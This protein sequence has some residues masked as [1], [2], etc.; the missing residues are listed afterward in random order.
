LLDAVFSEAGFTD[1]RKNNTVCRC[2]VL[3]V[4]IF[5]RW[6]IGGANGI[7]FC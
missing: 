1:H 2:Q 7:F 4:W 6:S 3:P 5:R